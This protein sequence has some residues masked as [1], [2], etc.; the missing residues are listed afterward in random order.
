MF[1]LKQLVLFIFV[2]LMVVACDNDSNPMTQS[3]DDGLATYNN[4]VSIAVIEVENHS[5]DDHEDHNDEGHAAPLGFDLEEEGQETY[6]Y[7]QLGLA[8]NG[9]I[10]LDVGETK[11]FSV[12]FL[13]CDDLTDQTDCDSF[14]EC[15]WD[16][17]EGLCFEDG[18]EHCDD[19]TGQTA[20]EA[21]DHCEWH[22]DDSSCEDE[23]HEHCDDFTGQTACEASEHCEWHADDSSC[24]DEEHG[25]HIEITG[26]QEGTTVFQIR[27]MHDGHADYVSL[28]IPVTVI[29]PTMFSCNSKEICLEK[30][31]SQ[32]IY[33]SR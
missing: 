15:D 4:D 33:A 11:E 8:V 22:A 3:I 5:D 24:E 23:G 14:V 26:V 18:H 19:L 6:T 21:S 2:G 25:M 1:N 7:R 13:D 16:T 9:S 17:D 29:N 27:L 31:C 28:N 20:C 12:H 30:C 10:T 32:T